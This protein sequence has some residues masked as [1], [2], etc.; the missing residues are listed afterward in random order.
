MKRLIIGLAIAMV[1][2]T[3]CNSN[4][5]KSAIDHDGMHTD[6]TTMQPHAETT[7]EAA[8]TGVSMNGIITGYL[9]LKNALTT[10]NSKGAS[11]A[12]TAL[13]TT[14]KNFDKNAL[15]AEQKKLFGD[16]EA[17]AREHAEHIAANAGNLAHQREHFDMLSKDMVD[18]LKAF[19]SGGQTLYK[20][21]CPM[22]ND[23]KG[24][25]WISETKDIKNP[26]YG[27]AMSTCGSVK[28]EF[29]LNG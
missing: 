1:S 3:A 12:G 25:F 15:S 26:Y 27:K 11:E 8:N 24:A 13:E 28:E 29:Q 18:L 10:D 6:S 21:F 14:F 7:N 20:D 2:F 16:I 19:G 4:D 9:Q 22:Y 17:D 5:Q 23:N